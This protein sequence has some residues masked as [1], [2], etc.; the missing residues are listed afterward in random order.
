MSNE[1]FGD[2]RDNM[3][4]LWAKF[5]SRKFPAGVYHAFYSLLDEPLPENRVIIPWSACGHVYEE[6]VVPEKAD[7]WP[8]VGVACRRCIKAV[9][10]QNRRALAK[11]VD[12]PPLRGDDS[13]TSPRAADGPTPVL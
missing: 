8:E 13:P 12:R 11:N 4:K 2:F 6:H 9:T 5:T 10:N 7:F 3:P 1:H